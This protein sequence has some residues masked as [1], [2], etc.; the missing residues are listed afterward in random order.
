MK[1][2]QC[3]SQN[4]YLSRSWNVRQGFVA[5]AQRSRAPEP[6]AAAEVVANHASYTPALRQAQGE[7]E[8]FSGEQRCCKPGFTLIEILVVLVIVGLLAGIALPRLAALYASVE[9]SGRRSAIHDQ[10]E[11]LGYLAY[12]SGKSIVLESSSESGGQTK[13]YP[14]QLPIGWEY[15]PITQ[16]LLATSQLAGLPDPR[17]NLRNTWN[18]V[19]GNNPDWF[20]N[21]IRKI[22]GFAATMVAVAR[23]ILGEA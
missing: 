20:T 14:L 11:G 7:R 8:F 19:P 23:E 5:H 22:I 15:T 3:R 10:I 13:D 16:E 2:L 6:D 12:A 9:N 18:L 21:L 1:R 17:N 4:C